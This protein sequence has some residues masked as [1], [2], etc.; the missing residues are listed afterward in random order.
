MWND[1]QI[2]EQPY[3]D[4]RNA[5]SP[6]YVSKAGFGRALLTALFAQIHERSAPQMEALLALYKWV[7]DFSPAE[8][9]LRNLPEMLEEFERGDSPTTAQKLPREFW[10]TF[11]VWYELFPLHNDVV[12]KILV[13]TLVAGIKHDDGT[14][15]HRSHLLNILTEIQKDLKVDELLFPTHISSPDLPDY[16]P[17]VEKRKD[18]MERVNQILKDY[19]EHCERICKLN[20]VVPRSSKRALQT[21]VKWLADRLISKESYSTLAHREGVEVASYQNAVVQL[22]KMMGIS[23][24]VR[25]KK[26]SKES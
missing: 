1:L 21:H 14:V 7:L 15:D 26:D 10:A 5:N 11:L 18:Y 12:V 17:L 23:E 16:N 25:K 4:I 13:S 3:E 8:A 9:D 19:V 6:E 20:G 24:E 2:N 22:A